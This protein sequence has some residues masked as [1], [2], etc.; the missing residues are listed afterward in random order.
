MDYWQ[1]ETRFFIRGENK[2]KEATYDWFL[3]P[4]NS[5]T[6]GVIA[7]FLAEH[8]QSDEGQRCLNLCD[9]KGR[10]HMVWEAD[11]STVAFL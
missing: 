3:A 4:A 7:S 8:N 9:N 5:H 1:S 11:Y 6:N 10:P 2:V